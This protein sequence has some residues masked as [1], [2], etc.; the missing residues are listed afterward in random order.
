[1]ASSLVG[2][3]GDILFGSD[4]Q[5][6]AIAAGA[7]GTAASDFQIAQIKSEARAILAAGRNA[8]KDVKKA[9]SLIRDLEDR[10]AEPYAFK[11][12]PQY[13]VA[14][15]L[16]YTFRQKWEPG[17]FQVGKLIA[18]V[19]LAP[20]ESRKIQKRLVI[21]EARQSK[22]LRRNVRNLVDES[23]TN[24]S[25]TTEIVRRAEASNTANVTA[26]GSYGND[27]LYRVSG[28][29]SAQRDAKSLSAETKQ[30]IR[31][32]TL[33]AV[34]EVREERQI[35]IDSTSEQT[36]EE[37]SSGEISNPNEEI[38]VTYLYYELQRQYNVSEMLHKITPVIFVA[39]PF[40]APNDID[41]G[42]LIEHEWILRRV[43]LDN[44]FLPSL[45]A[46]K[47]S[48]DGEL[49]SLNALQAAMESAF[50]A[51]AETRDY[52]ATQERL[53]DLA[54]KRL[55]AAVDQVARVQAGES[56]EGLGEKIT[57]FFVGSSPSES[58]DAATTRRDAAES[59]FSRIED[60]IA[61]ARS[62]LSQLE[63]ALETATKEYVDALKAYTESIQQITALR[64]HV[65][66]N[67]TYYMQAIWKCEHRDQRFFTL[68][69]KAVPFVPIDPT[70][71]TVSTAADGTVTIA[72][73][74][75]GQVV[76]QRLDTIADLDNLIGFMGNYL[77]FPLTRACH[78]T[79]DMMTGFLNSELELEDPDASSTGVSIGEL[80]NAIAV[81]TS[82][83]N[84]LP[85]NDP[86]RQQYQDEIDKVTVLIDAMDNDSNI[87]KQAE[88][89]IVPSDMLYI[90]ALPGANPVIE[91]FKLTHRQLD[92]EQARSKV[93]QSEINNLRLATL[94]RSGNLFDPEID[95]Q[96]LINAD[97]SAAATL[98]ELSA[99]EANDGS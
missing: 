96:I 1:M 41:R 49:L 75:T 76:Q 45:D 69:D 70:A 2:W 36:S 57:E 20:R 38:T 32:K 83:A 27:E 14:Y 60:S 5:G 7:D 77:I 68:F 84:A 13:S 33:K 74:N 91:N 56:S 72:L 50:R 85:Q 3:I 44:S 89:V 64:I 42:W 12:F 47:K 8:V 65:K 31:Q 93:K 30:A 40:P 37:T 22:E 11:V 24:T 52:I 15:G 6:D 4:H 78:L 25:T 26:S 39:Y 61:A 98:S 16:L 99:L 21:R 9:R 19:P 46:L 95:K 88:M 29:A 79:T 62:R 94:L 86:R 87:T 66:Q 55:D 54:S 67:I 17:N 63:S 34:Q 81:L 73:P 18:T 97:S 51:V 80:Q 71:V 43:I 59:F 28:Q 90:E 82:Q 35:E 23:T 10:L 53:K 58:S 92:A 48:P